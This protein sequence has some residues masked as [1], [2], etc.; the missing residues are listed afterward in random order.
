[1]GSSLL[2]FLS[3]YLLFNLTLTTQ[4]SPELLFEEGYTVTTVV[5]GDKVHLNPNSVL[6][7]HGLEKLILLD[8]SASTFYSL[9]FPVSQESTIKKLTGNSAA[10]YVDGE[11]GSAKFNKPKSF[12]VDY[13]GNIYVA[14]KGNHAI[15]KITMSG[16]T[17]IAG[18]YIQ[19]AG[20]ADGPAKDATFSDD[21]EL[22]FVPEQCALMI[23]DHGNR[24][25]RQ[26]NLKAEDCKQPSNNVLGSTSAWILGLA[27]SCIL[28]I[29]IGFVMRPFVIPQGGERLR[30][31]SETWNHSLI[32]LGRL[33]GMLCC[34]IKSAIVSSTFYSPLRNLLKF[35]LSYL[36]LIFRIRVVEPRTYEKP[37]S[38][39]DIDHLKNKTVSKSLIIADQLR[40]LVSF[41]E[42][43]PLSETTSNLAKKDESNVFH[44]TTGKIDN[45]IK[46]NMIDF[47][48]QA[49]QTSLIQANIMDFSHQSTQV[50]VANHTEDK[51]GLIKRK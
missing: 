14:D 22:A 26:I 18:G 20:H 27:I 37:V 36:A 39:L 8:S 31:F 7:Q 42:V 21:F 33:P 19:K 29:V 43:H 1:M 16:V 3:F 23:S 46:A 12:A 25:V 5:D 30:L 6:A 35:F 40:E 11:L 45:M 51:L 15:R 50:S 24:L 34:D 28:G 41:D 4:V 17:T 49:T 9:S 44:G 38:L 47:E 2:S 13:R 48:V 10:D 32:S